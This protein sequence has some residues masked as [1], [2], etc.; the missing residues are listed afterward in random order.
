MSRL[1]LIF[2]IIGLRLLILFWGSIRG[3][4]KEKGDRKRGWFYYKFALK[5]KYLFLKKT[6]RNKY[7]SLGSGDK[8]LYPKQT[9]RSHMSIIAHKF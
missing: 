5:K 4:G 8:F 2:S 6:K 7:S 9:K 1:Y 3:P